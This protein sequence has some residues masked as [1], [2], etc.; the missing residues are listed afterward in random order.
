MKRSRSDA[1]ARPYAWLCLALVALVAV[2][3]RLHAL[4]EVPRGLLFD[5]AING[6]DALN[7]LGGWRPIFLPDNFGREP[8][9]IYLQAASVGLLGRT[10]LALRLPAALFSLASMVVAYLLMRRL[11]GARVALLASAWYAVSFWDLV[12]SRLGLR[13]ISLPFFLCASCYFLWQGIEAKG[14]G[15]NAFFAIAGLFLGASLYTYTSARFAPFVLLG[16]ALYLAVVDWSRFRANFGGFVVAAVVAGL[17]FLPEGWYFWRHPDVF[18]HR[19]LAVSAVLS[20]PDATTPAAF[21]RAVAQN[22]GIFSFSGDLD[23][24]RNL[25]GRP[26]LDPLTS[27]LGAVG[28]VLTLRRIRRPANGLVLVWMVVMLLPSL[29]TTI[30][31][32]NNLRIV[33]IIP[34]PFLFPALAVDWLWDGWT[35]R[36]PR[37]SLV[38]WV[39]VA[40]AT[41]AGGLSVDRTY[42]ITWATAPAVSDVFNADRWTAISAARQLV[43]SEHG[44]VYVAAGDADEPLQEYLLRGSPDATQLRLFDGTRTLILPTKAQ[45]TTYVVAQRDLDALALLRRIF[46]RVTTNPGP[47]GPDGRPALV[48]RVPADEASL[49]PTRPLSARFGSQLRV[50]GFDLDRDVAAGGALR[51]RW[52]WE[53]L[54]PVPRQLTFFNQVLGDDEQRVGQLDAP[55]FEPGYWP[56][57]TRGVSTFDVPIDPN[58]PTGV[59]RL[60]VGAYDPQTLDRLPVLDGNGKEAGSALDLG[61]I[62]VHGRPAPPPGVAIPLRASFADG[63][64]LLGYDVQPREA[65]PGARVTLTLDWSARKRPSTDYTVFVHMLDARGAPVAGADAP[66]RSGLD[67]TSLWDAGDAIADPHV[68]QIPADVPP[69]VY[70]LEIGL[71]Q[72]SSGKRLSRADSNADNLFLGNFFVH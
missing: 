8:L 56:T 20:A 14:R 42:F 69:G 7:I 46:P 59:Y 57:G 70:R 51:V 31:I 67:P 49:D 36:L 34:L 47:A 11:F 38:P 6:V 52:Y 62:K 23:W 2:Y 13:A 68:L 39:M 61:P 27:L 63:V 16:F 21:A 65:R 12:L 1:S 64:E 4:A 9:F 58:V 37:L 71:Y 33:G 55:A 30:Q 40:L 44:T 26:L 66:P 43:A 19:A 48:A 29:L 45:A 18:F 17:V 15:P 3:L 41:L 5:E 35:E 25:P 54:G 24:S 72:P 53:M 60:V 10:D 22:L 50:L 32:P 28:L